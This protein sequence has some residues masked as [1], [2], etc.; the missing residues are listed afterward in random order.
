ML[1]SPL[2]FATI[3]ISDNIYLSNSPGG[4]ITTLVF[5]V[6]ILEGHTGLR[7]LPSL[8]SS[9]ISGPELSTAST[10]V[11]SV[12]R[13]WPFKL[14]PWVLSSDD[15]CFLQI[16]FVAPIPHPYD[17]QL[18]CFWSQPTNLLHFPKE[19]AWFWCG[20][21]LEMAFWVHSLSPQNWYHYHFS[22]F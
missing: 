22:C 10:S 18:G 7:L 16:L 14:V 6:S 8:N 9:V 3:Y 11:I 1:H 13:A 19:N 17:L 4:G 5:I 21:F 15:K 20:S 12:V 2:L